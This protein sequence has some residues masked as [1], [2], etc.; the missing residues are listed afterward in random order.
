MYTLVQLKSKYY[1]CPRFYFYSDNRN[2]HPSNP[3]RCKDTN[4]ERDGYIEC[5][6]TFVDRSKVGNY[7]LSCSYHIMGSASKGVVIV[8]HNTTNIPDIFK[9]PDYIITDDLD[10]E[11][12]RCIYT[13]IDDK[14]LMN[15]WELIQER[16][17]INHG[18]DKTQLK[19]LMNYDMEHVLIALDKAFTA[20]SEIEKDNS[21]V[22]ELTEMLDDFQ[23]KFTQKAAI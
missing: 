15:L 16:R 14:G 7:V 11:D 13:P 20:K 4:K 9:S 8:Y 18:L 17:M 6:P 22:R 12:P 23:A 5:N 10:D 21:K 2:L 19:L 1:I 3:L